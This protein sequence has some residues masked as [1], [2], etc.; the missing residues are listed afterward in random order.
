M[1][2]LLL[3]FKQVNTWWDFEKQ[4]SRQLATSRLLFMEVI[5]YLS[6]AHWL[7][8]LVLFSLAVLLVLAQ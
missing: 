6:F 2:A 3:I 7:V 8:L 4:I 5:N 1:R